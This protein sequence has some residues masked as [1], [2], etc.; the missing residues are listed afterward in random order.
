MALLVMALGFAGIHWPTSF[1]P[2]LLWLLPAPAVLDFVAEHVVASL[3]S[4]IRQKILSGLAAVGFGRGLT[5]YLQHP[6]DKLF[7]TVAITY[8]LLMAASAIG[9]HLYDQRGA[10][11]AADEES[12]NWWAALQAEWDAQPSDSTSPGS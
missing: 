9:R 6:G 3:Y 5:R 2:V 4:P 10:R 1:D 11:R 8:S 7:W 12:D